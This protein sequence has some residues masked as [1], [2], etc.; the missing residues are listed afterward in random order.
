L[1]FKSKYYLTTK[2]RIVKLEK[3]IKKGKNNNGNKA[4]VK[5]RRKAKKNRKNAGEEIFFSIHQ[6]RI[7]KSS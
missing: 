3:K 5:K 1:C 2:E 6:G 4:A 7:L